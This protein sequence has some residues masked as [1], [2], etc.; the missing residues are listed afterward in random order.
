MT[1]TTL[2]TDREFARIDDE[3]VAALRNMIGKPIRSDRPHITEL[4]SDAIRHYAFGIGDRNPLWTEPEYTASQGKPQ[5][6]PPSALLAMD[7]VFSGY[8]TGLPGIHAMYAGTTFEFER[9]LQVGDK[10]KGSATLKELIERPSKF[11][12]RSWQ[13]IYE[14][15]FHDPE[16]NLV[17]TGHSYCFRI[18][19]DNARENKKYE[20]IRVEW[21]PD[22]IQEIAQRYRDEEARRRGDKPLYIDEV[23]VGDKLPALTKGPYTATTAIAYLLG[24]GGLYVRGHGDAFDLFNRHPALGIP[25]EWGV[26]EPPERVHWDPDLAR[27]VGV[28]GAYDYGPERVSWM[29][30][31][32]TDWMGDAGFMKYLD[33]QVRRHNVLGEL[34]TCDGEITAVD[35]ATRTVEIKLDAVNQDGHE[36]ARGTARVVLPAR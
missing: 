36:S 1:D 12:G 22:Q 19:R 4:T 31:V 27:R 14:V 3:Q 17:C 5:L 25:N 2:E 15:P 6:A 9:P 18:E 32:I 24:W 35:T 13:Q 33:V 34:V 23:K 10:L 30:H 7:K 28:P 20:E 8:V 21:T 26:P 16:G 11:A 29:S